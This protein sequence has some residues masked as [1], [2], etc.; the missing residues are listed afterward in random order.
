M[1]YT[2]SKNDYITEEIT[3]AIS[4]KTQETEKLIENITCTNEEIIN[5]DCKNV[6]IGNLQIKEIYNSLAKDI[7]QNKANIIINQI[8]LNKFPLL[9]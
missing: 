1:E 3:K 7:K 5:N 8:S 4:T 2:E 9:I 6:E